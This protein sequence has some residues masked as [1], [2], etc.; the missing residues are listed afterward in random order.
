ML[1][2]ITFTPNPHTLRITPSSTEPG[3]F[4]WAITRDGVV[5]RQSVRSFASQGASEANGDAALR[6][7]TF[8]WR[9]A[10]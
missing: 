10:R 5:V 9:G 4:D 7:V 2:M 3:R 6:D 1:N 8:Q